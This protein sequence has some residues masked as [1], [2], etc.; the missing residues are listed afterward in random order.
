[1]TFRKAGERLLNGLLLL[2]IFST[3]EAGGE[4][5]SKRKWSV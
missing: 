3:G 1:M 5:F 2:I 4:S